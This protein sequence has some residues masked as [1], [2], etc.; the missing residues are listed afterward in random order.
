MTATISAATPQNLNDPLFETGSSQLDVLRRA[1]R[2]A[3]ELLPI[4]GPINVFV[5][6][7]TLQAFE[8]LPFDEGVRKA[9]DLFHCEPYLP[10]RN[11]REKAERGRIRVED[12]IGELRDDLGPAAEEPVLSFGTRFQIR[13]AMLRFPL[14]EATGNEL[15]WLMAESDA[16]RTF[17]TEMPFATRQRVLQETRQWGRSLAG[18]A[19]HESTSIPPVISALLKERSAL[20][21]DRWSDVDWE[22]FTLEALWRIC[23]HGVQ[24]VH[25]PQQRPRPPV[26]HRDVILHATGHDSDLLIHEVLIRFCAAF[27]DQGFAEW[28]LPRRDQGFAAA[29]AWLHGDAAHHPERWRAGLSAQLRPMLSPD[30]Q[31]LD[32]IQESL[33]RLG[34]PPDGIRYERFSYAAAGDRKA[35][36]TRNAFLIMLA[37]IAIG[38]ALFA[39]RPLVT[40]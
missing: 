9:A 30:F 38:I 34:V 8:N 1:I 21:M 29:F 37:A 13:L 20:P 32:S 35:R 10:E 15:Q 2:Q 18:L 14:Q 7:N 22:A 16:L 26:R 19:S 27:L 33:E 12:L 3:A 5:A 36:R 17:R 25:D 28:G 31:P 6:M 39:T 24:A 4:Q 23:R 11:Y 40:G